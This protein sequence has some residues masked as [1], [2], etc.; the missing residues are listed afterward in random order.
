MAVR[1]LDRLVAAQVAGLTLEETA[2]I[3]RCSVSTVQRRLRQEAVQQLIAERL[4]RQSEDEARV[5]SELR[6][7]AMRVF[8][9]SMDSDDERIR[10]RAAEKV[11]VQADRFDV[12]N[13][14]AKKQASVNE[15]LLLWMADHGD[16]DL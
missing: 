11:A 5:W 13:E 1:D 3:C 16:G 7:T 8:R 4:E 6:H 10:L 12:M 2:S 9:E 14:F 15:A